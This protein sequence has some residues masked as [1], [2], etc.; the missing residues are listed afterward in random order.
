VAEETHVLLDIDD[1]PMKQLMF[2]ASAAKKNR[3]DKIKAHQMALRQ[4]QQQT[5]R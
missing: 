4:Q 3:E 2:M 5:K 1:V